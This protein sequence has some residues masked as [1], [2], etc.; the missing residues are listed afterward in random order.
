MADRNDTEDMLDIF[1]YESL[2]LLEDLQSVVLANKDEN[3]F[4]EASINDIFRIMHTLKASSGIMMYDNITRISHKLEDVIYYIR[5][6]Q[7]DNMPQEELVDHIFNVMDFIT[8]ELDKIQ[9][10]DPSDGDPECIIEEIDNFINKVKNIDSEDGKD[11]P[12]ENI[13][14]E[15]MQFYI[16]PK[17]VSQSKFYSVIIYYEHDTEMCNLR[18]YTD[19][20][21]VKEVADDLLYK[22]DDIIYNDECSDYI[23]ENG[24][25]L[26]IHTKVDKEKLL[27]IID[28]SLCV[29]NI[30]IEEISVEQFMA[31]LDAGEESAD[32]AVEVTE[33]NVIEHE[34]IDKKAPAPGDYVIQN[35]TS[36]KSMQMGREKSAPHKQNLISVSVE[37]MDMLMDLLGEMIIAQSVALQNQDILD[38]GVEMPNFK[39][40]A[41]ELT[42]ISTRLQN[43]VM[44]MRMIS[45]KNTFQKMSRVVFDV[46]KKLGKEIDLEVLGEDTEVDR[47]IIE[48]ISDPLMHLIRNSVDHGIEM[49]SDR[50]A[51][52]KLRRGKI[53]LSAKNEAGKVWITVSDDGGGL[54]RKKILERAEK[55]G[56]LEDKDPSMMTD[57]E[58]YKLITHAGFTTKEQIT[59]FSGRGVGMDVVVNNIQAIGGKLQIDS[60][61]GEGSNMTIKIPLT[62]ATINGVVMSVGDSMYVIDTNVVKAFINVNSDMILKEPGGIENVNLRGNYIP[63]IRLREYFKLSDGEDEIDNGIMVLVEHK[64]KGVCLFAD[65]LIGE[66]EIIVKSV[67]SYVEDEVGLS[68]CTQL[69]DGN[70]A[71]ILDAGGLVSR[72]PKGE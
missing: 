19:A 6:S 53:T 15:P 43:V 63:I 31:G 7:P 33:S 64:G 70:V 34:E 59:E 39:K 38:L 66:Q 21:S 26:L 51:A 28:T 9:N 24:F 3:Y 69:G 56:I 4:D 1:L 18:A 55:N 54:S 36:G 11:A 13:H 20:C 37:K 32:T 68:G 58:V 35:K 14:E 2:Q 67:P 17:S 45:L 65:R 27:E 62:L 8:E 5:E 52:G 50:E 47:N 10:G 40:A 29:E 49:P 72:L 23:L 60:V 46:S 57:K 48:H 41:G 30:E 44:S 61:E 22:P 16:A 12:P 25:K 71:M 42:K